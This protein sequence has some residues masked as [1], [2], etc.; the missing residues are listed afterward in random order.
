MKHRIATMMAGVVAA[1]FIAGA[2]IAEVNGIQ[3]GKMK[4]M[5]TMQGGMMKRQVVA[6][7]D[8]GIII[9]VGNL[10]IKYDRDLNRVNKTTIEISDEEMQQ[11]MKKM[12]KHCDMCRRMCQDIMKD[13]SVADEDE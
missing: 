12:V 1:T 8:G 9:I 10:L 5:C 13:D 11:M 4:D 7:N 6:T 3:Q 2:A